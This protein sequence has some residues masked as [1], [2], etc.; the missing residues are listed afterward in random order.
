MKVK[1]VFII[2]LLGSFLFATVSISAKVKAQPVNVNVG[3]PE[4]LTAKTAKKRAVADPD[5]FDG[6]SFPPEERP[7]EGI[8]SDFEFGSNESGSGEEQQLKGSGG[9]EEKEGNESGGGQG[10]TEEAETAGGSSAEETEPQSTGASGGKGQSRKPPEAVKLGDASQQIPVEQSQEKAV[11]QASSEPQQNDQNEGKSANV[12]Q[13]GGKRS[14]GVE[15]G[16]AMPT[17]L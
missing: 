2:T 16:D 12:Q 13:S 5:I 8:L 3:K 14:R 4:V 9:Q 15:K 6:S 11:G 1:N 10:G 7:E 17:D